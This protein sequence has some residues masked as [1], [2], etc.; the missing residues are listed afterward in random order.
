MDSKKDISI[1]HKTPSP[2]EVF[3]GNNQALGFVLKKAEKL[4]GAVYMLT[5]FMPKDEPLAL[6]IKGQILKLLSYTARSVVSQGRGSFEISQGLKE[7]VVEILSLIEVASMSGFISVMNKNILVG[8]FNMLISVMGE[9]AQKSGIPVSKTDFEVSTEDS[10]ELSQVTAIKNKGQYKH[11]MS[12]NGNKGVRDAKKD[13]NPVHKRQRRE[14]IITVFKKEH[15]FLS[16]KDINIQFKDFS[17]KT[18]QREL[19][20]LVEEGVLKKE[21]E[22]RW[23]KYILK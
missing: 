1:N 10:V 7:I 14:D 11:E 16:V 23:S 18:I 3:V 22:R 6:S 5:G 12:L 9:E 8:E 13:S 21:G 20:A 19:L 4:A 17:E 15:R 2:I